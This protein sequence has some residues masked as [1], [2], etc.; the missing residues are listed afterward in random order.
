MLLQAGNGF[1]NQTTQFVNGYIKGW[2]SS[3]P[4]GGR[5]EPN[6]DPMPTLASCDCDRGLSSA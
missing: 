3:K 5:A 4:N 2:C 1:A 6:D